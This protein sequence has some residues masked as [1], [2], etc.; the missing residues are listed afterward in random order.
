MTRTTKSGR[1]LQ[2]LGEFDGQVFERGREVQQA[3]EALD[4]N[5]FMARKHGLNL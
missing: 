2:R 5:L 3:R 4:G 1:A